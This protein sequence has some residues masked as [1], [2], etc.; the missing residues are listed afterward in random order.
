[1]EDERGTHPRPT[2]C[3]QTSLIT[4][5]KVL[6]FSLAIKLSVSNSRSRLLQRGSVDLGLTFGQLTLDPNI[7]LLQQG[8]GPGSVLDIRALAR[9]G[10]MQIFVAFPDGI[11]RTYPFDQD[12]TVLDLKELILD[13]TAIPLSAQNLLLG[14][15]YLE[16]NRFLLQY[17]IQN[18]ST[19]HCIF[20]LRGTYFS[21]CFHF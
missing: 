8:V 7:P 10:S 5:E 1:M 16:N 6:L 2:W 17:E 21:L 18:E 13:N 14:C 12:T 15:Q 9:A 3:L 19:L 11:T 20:R 4:F